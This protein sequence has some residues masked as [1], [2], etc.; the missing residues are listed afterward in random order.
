MTFRSAGAARNP[1]P[2]R[3]YPTGKRQSCGVRRVRPT[4]RLFVTLRNALD[5]D[6]YRRCFLARAV[7]AVRDQCGLRNDETAKF[8][9]AR[10]VPRRSALRRLATPAF[11]RD[12]VGCRSDHRITLGDVRRG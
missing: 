4:A 3:N 11:G 1:L 8:V 7:P 5:T 6:L 9:D 12:Y 10:A 2:R